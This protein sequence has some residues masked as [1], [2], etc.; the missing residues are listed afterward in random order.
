MHICS[1]SIFANSS[2]NSEVIRQSMDF[3]SSHTSTQIRASCHF[4]PRFSPQDPFERPQMTLSLTIKGN[5]GSL[6]GEILLERVDQ[7]NGQ[8]RK[9][10]PTNISARESHC[11]STDSRW[12]TYLASI[13]G[14]SHHIL[15]CICDTD[16]E[17]LDEEARLHKQHE[18]LP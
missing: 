6:R 17:W 1:P 8:E 7:A 11:F 15:L 2:A 14:Q 9:G 18:K 13:E 12:I 16:L 5:V 3:A 4:S 10:I